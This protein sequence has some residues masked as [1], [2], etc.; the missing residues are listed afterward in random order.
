[1]LLDIHTHQPASSGNWAIQNLYKN[2]EQV[3]LHGKYSIGLHPWYINEDNWQQQFQL[4]TQYGNHA[5]VLAIGECG[6][7]K[8]CATSFD[9]QVKVFTAQVQLANQINKPLIIHCVRAYNELLQ[10]LKQ[11]Q[12]KVPVA[13]HGFNKNIQIAEQIV[14]A[15]YYLSFGKALQEQHLQQV[16]ATVPLSN[17]LLETDDA[18][19]DIATIY[20]LAATALHMDVDKLA[21]QIQQNAVTIFGADYFK[22]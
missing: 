19:I 14:A 2:F 4:I 20:Q 3:A 9:L 21:L 10:I 13:F 12:N 17:I 18:A 7:D 1:M 8:V 15:G 22:L 5:H 16:L 6:L 11:Q